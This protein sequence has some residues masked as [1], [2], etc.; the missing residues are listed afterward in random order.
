[1]TPLELEQ[2]GFSKE[3]QTIFEK[4]I[5]MRMGLILITGPTGSGKT[6]TLY[7]GLNR[8]KSPEENIL[9]VEDPVEYHLD[10]INQVEV[11]TKIGLTFATGLRAFLRQDPD[12]I[13]VGE[14]RDLETAQIC[15]RASLTGHLVFS[16]IHTNDTA[17]AVTRL[18]DIGVEPYL[19]TSSLIMAV[20]QRLM[21]RLCPDCKE[22]HIPNEE[23]I[24]DFG[25]K[26]K[27]IYKAKGCK[28]CRM[29]GYYGQ[30][31]IYELLEVNDEIKDLAS[32]NNAPHVIKAAACKHGMRTLRESAF[33]KVERGIT[34]IEEALRATMGIE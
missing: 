9:T 26:A 28:K 3:E 19:V 12:I 27:T 20:A 21:R 1:M 23:E 18:I 8:I 6:T 25:I 15:I 24:H 5:N 32:K 7:A 31:A 33:E 2:L 29:T 14:V 34:C 30:V 17:S 11:R 4:Y 13:M 10:G 22:A 16:T